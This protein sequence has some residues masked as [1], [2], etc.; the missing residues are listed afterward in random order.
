MLRAT[1]S[2]AF[3]G[4]GHCFTCKTFSARSNETLKKKNLCYC[5]R[6]SAS[7]YLITGVHSS[8]SVTAGVPRSGSVGLPSAGTVFTGFHTSTAFTPL[9][10][11]TSTCTLLVSLS[12]GL[13]C[14]KKHQI[15][16]PL[17]LQRAHSA[18]LHSGENYH[19]F[20]GASLTSHRPPRLTCLPRAREAHTAASLSLPSPSVRE[21]GV[22]RL[23]FR[24]GS[25]F[26]ERFELAFFNSN[27]ERCVFV[28]RT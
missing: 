3:F 9:T 23:A 10:D 1:F 15:K 26:L 13:S 17:Q 16:R 5:T 19:D 18:F 22:D 28:V 4:Y 2:A 11:C 6:S 25:I 20:F 27:R 7:S 24:R 8:S 12:A 14:G 21:N